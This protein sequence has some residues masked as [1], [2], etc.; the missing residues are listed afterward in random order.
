MPL[1]Q[2]EPRTL[3]CEFSYGS[4]ELVRTYRMGGGESAS[5]I[6][7]SERS[8]DPLGH[9]WD[10]FLAGARPRNDESLTTLRVTDLFCG[11][12]GLAL[13]VRQAADELGFSVESSVALDHDDEAVSLYA[14]NHAT[15]HPVAG[16]ITEH[17][18]FRTRGTGAEATFRYPPQT[19]GHP[20]DGLHGRIHVVTAGPPC[21][22]HS[23]LNNHSR[24][25]DPRNELYL[26]VPAMAVALDA[27]MVIIENVPEVTQAV[28]EVVAAAIGLLEASGY[29]VETGVLRAHQLGWPQR[30][31][32]FFLVASRLVEPLPLSIV[33]EGLASDPRPVS[34]A[35]ERA[36]V[37]QDHH[38][39]RLP[40]M[41]DENQ[42]RLDWLFDNDQFDLALDERPECHQDGTTY[43]SVYG[44][45]NPDAPA[46]TI[47]TGF[48]TMGRGRFVHPTERRVLNPAEAAVLQGFPRGYDFHTPDGENPK[49]V[50]L[51]KWIGNA[52]PMPLGHAAALSLLL[53]LVSDGPAGS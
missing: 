12:G 5:S 26:S 48:L 9:W 15:L 1:L 45:L 52:V 36:G 29:S 50:S 6:P 27:P 10:R 13:G 20:W 31:R 43:G 47:T 46:D 39:A 24:R 8:T 38:M 19:I 35:L 49:S 51:T 41:S 53:P 40:T 2:T 7:V 11:A 17:I 23:N 33:A 42:R 14:R 28:D 18:D 21:Q 32:R 34:W 3:T 4:D 22:G 44:R 25:D 37:D 16:S 30:R